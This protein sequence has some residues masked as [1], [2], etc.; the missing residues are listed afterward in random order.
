[1][2]LIHLSDLHLG[3]RVN[4]F[5]MLEDQEFILTRII[6]IIDGEKP[7]AVILAGDLYDK[8]VPPAEAV[9]LLDHFLVRLVRRSLQVFAISGNH[10]SPERI[11]FA[12]RLIEPCGVHLSP[13]YSGVIEPVTLQ[14]AFGPVHFYMLPF[15]KPAHV[16][17]FF[18]ERE[19]ASYTDAVQV[20]IEQMHMDPAERNVLITHQFVTGAERSESE[21]VSVGGA[22]NVDASVFDGIDYVALGHIH[23]PQN[24][25]T[26]RIRYCG[27]PLKYSFSEAAHIK[28]VTV[29][30][31]REKGALELRT[32]PLVPKR[33][34]RELRGSYMELTARSNYEGTN[35]EDYLHIT[36]T[37]EEDIPDVAA[38]LRV[39]YPNLM[40]LD[41][42]NRRTRSRSVVGAAEDVERKTPLELLGELYEKQNGAP[43]SEEQKAF[44][45]GLMES[46]WE[47]SV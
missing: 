37:D 14:D 24:I 18:P 28:S 21:E 45:A 44:S 16:R 47:G 22:D 40:K 29:V 15:V 17:R 5:S 25:D 41:Y 2:K 42:D 36:L 43:L 46:I 38:K 20:A 1:M 33:D 4:E 19:I 23:G 27:T 11:A 30:E 9:T 7:D 34:L 8:S 6:N 31:L 39:I 35:T 32:V 13:V 12:S 26:E 10:D 3:K